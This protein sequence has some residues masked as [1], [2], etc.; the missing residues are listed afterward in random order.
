MKIARRDIL[1]A[2][3]L[4]GGIGVL[5]G[6]ALESAA[7]VEMGDFR[8]I[9]S[10]SRCLLHHRDPYKFDDLRSEYLS[11]GGKVPTGPRDLRTLNDGVLRCINLPT[12]LF[13]V[14][15][16]AAL[17]WGWAHLVWMLLIVSFSLLAAFVIFHE[18]ARYANGPPFML[19]AIFLVDLGNVVFSG[20]LAGMVISLCVLAAW[21][22]LNDKHQW[23]AVVCF[24]VA[25]LMKPHDAGFI[26]LYFLIA[27]SPGRKRAL[28]ALLLVALLAA[29]ALV[30]VSSNSPGWRGEL[31]ANLHAGAARGGY[32]NPGPSGA[33]FDHS[34]MPINLQA[35]LSVYKDDPQFDNSLS[36]IVC[37]G[38]LLALLIRIAVTTVTQRSSWIALASLAALTMLPVYH[39]DY[40]ARLLLLAV[41]A[42]A[43][44]WCEGRGKWIALILSAIA[45]TAT[46]TLPFAFLALALAKTAPYFLA[47]LAPLS[48][49]ALGLFYLWVYWTA[50]SS[51]LGLNGASIKSA[52]ARS[53]A[54][55]AWM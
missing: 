10:A 36:Y 30:W 43:L 50:F 44:L 18:S 14:L 8:A 45:I 17:P 55:T 33:D 29:P 9:Y 34:H 46:A 41:P 19:I 21:L 53:S 28:Q 32:N 48:L 7:S 22:L 42:C 27:P 24:A 23:V 16:L 4:F 31:S 39:R 13:L 40:D 25:L 11:E 5:W 3:L 38:L 54:P 26:W 35:A 1:L 47:Q 49:L 15:P 12:A 51:R 20:N 2:V 52:C 6:V 37:G